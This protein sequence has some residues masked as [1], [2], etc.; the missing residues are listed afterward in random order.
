[1][2]A[3]ALTDIGRQRSVNQDTVLAVTKPIGALP[4]LFLVA[5]GMGGARAGDYASR[6]TV[7]YLKEYITKSDAPPLKALTL[8]IQYANEALYNEALEDE[9]LRG[10]G[11]TLV[12]ATLIEGILYVCNIGDSRLYLIRNEILQIT[13]D[14]SYVEELA[15]KGEISRES[16]EYFAYKN[17]ITRAI[18]VDKEIEI[19]YFDV[20]LRK[21]D[22]VLLCSD[23]LSNMVDNEKMKEIIDLSSS[24][25]AAAMTLIDKA[26]INGGNDNISVVLI[27]ADGGEV[28]A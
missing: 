15:V 16:S 19:D 9:K 23:G 27:S 26:N 14:H 24:L 5:D 3:V 18:G 4:N 13:N 28:E 7:R 12:A 21:G 8:A 22:I 25:E 6:A 1:M 10:M 2:R 11:T 20:E 17:L